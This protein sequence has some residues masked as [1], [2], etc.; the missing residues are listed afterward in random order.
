MK[1]YVP[2][3]LALLFLGGVTGWFLYRYS[4]ST[5]DKRESNFAVENASDISRILL[6]AVDGRKVELLKTGNGWKM[7]GSFDVNEEALSLL[8]TSIQ[9]V[10]AVSPVA[11]P[12]QKNVLQEM[13]AS[14]TRVQIFT[15]DT[16]RP[17][18]VY[19]VG[20]PTA[21][22]DGTFMI[23]EIDGQP[24]SQ[25]YITAIPGLR[26]YLTVRYNP[27][28]EQWRNRWIYRENNRTIE[29]VSV[30]YYGHPEKSF[31][32]KLASKDS[33]AIWNGDDEPGEQPKQRF[34]QQYLDFY[35]ALSME[36]Y[37]N[38][39]K[40][41]DSILMQQPYCT[42]TVKAK[43]KP[44]ATTVLYY[45][46]LNKRSIR[47]FDEEGRELLY[48]AEHYYATINNNRDFVLIQYYVWGKVLRSY[49]DFFVKP[50]AIPGKM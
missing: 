21:N 19:V 34:I 41:K 20:G 30:N 5:L 12:A 50:K 43:G 46:P 10:K 48:D 18:K 14:S 25:P 8:L 22:A 44:A 26:A 36:A 15:D 33:F 31:S 6:T 28:V 39:N 23:M 35:Q 40:I 42:F 11:V 24:A 45:M 3:L 17:E 4:P 1:K 7:N 38:T 32:I 47:R 16:S 2:H 49:S 29:S 27:D 9:K 13:H 37:E